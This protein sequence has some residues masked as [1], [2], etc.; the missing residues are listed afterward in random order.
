M[1]IFPADISF[2]ESCNVGAGSCKNRPDQMILRLIG[3]NRETAAVPKDKTDNFI[4]FIFN[5]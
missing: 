2:C 4:I 1:K 3:V 5:R